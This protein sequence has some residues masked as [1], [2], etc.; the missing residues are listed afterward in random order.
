MKLFVCFI[1]VLV[2]A[3][4][5]EVNIDQVKV[6]YTYNFLKHTTWQNESNLNEY[7]ILVVSRNE[8][9]KNMF[10]MLS[11]RKQLNNKKIRISFYDGTKQPK[12]IQAVYVDSY[13]TPLYNKL[14][15]AYESDNVLFV[16]DE[17]KD[18]KKVMINLLYDGEIVTFEINKANILNRS[19]QI[20]PDLILLGGSEIDV[21]KLYRSSQSELKEQ[22]ETIAGLNKN[23]NEKNSELSEKTAAIEKQKAEIAEQKSKI[24]FQKSLISQ[25][26][27]SIDEQNDK[28]HTQQKEL[29]E[30]HRNI[31]L[32]RKQLVIEEEKIK[33]KEAVLQQLLKSH[34]DKQQEIENAG[35][36]LERLNKQ[37]QR[38]KDNLIHKEGIIST[39]KG[40]IGALLILV[41]II[42]LLVV[43]VFKQNAQLRNLS[44]TDPLTGLFNR[45]AFLNKLHSEILK[46]NRYEAPL[47]ILLMDVDHFKSVNDIYGHDRG[48]EILKKLAALMNHNTRDTDICVRWGG[49]EFLILATNTNLENGV[50]L[51]RH[52]KQVVE[53]N[54]FG[55]DKPVTVSIGIATM[56]PGLDKDELIKT[57][58]RALY[59]A[60][61]D[62]R[63][64]IVY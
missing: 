53:S 59:K 8:S 56:K 60:K 13:N 22:K 36:E 14:F 2:S 3:F 47:S 61:N 51:A 54:D 19:L 49:E 4:A 1:L 11:S 50:K 57:A 17:Y 44:Q 5:K 43:F 30:I 46:F 58:D 48:D 40:A 37:I 25:Q 7:H 18:Q 9:L 32:Q 41:G 16:S 12:N 39:Q 31:E 42:V 26:L 64:H 23:I 62:G 45:R 10:R 33:E 28:I 29:D 15:D 21:A 24:E 63:N 52:F 55:L 6:A 38:Q 35:I 20:S 27:H 34:E